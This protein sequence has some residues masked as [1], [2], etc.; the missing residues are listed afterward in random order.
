MNNL[1]QTELAQYILIV[2]GSLLLSAAL[3][4]GISKLSSYGIFN[5]K[6]SGKAVVQRPTV[7][8]QV[9]MLHRPVRISARPISNIVA[10]PVPVSSLQETVRMTFEQTL[11]SSQ[12]LLAA[13]RRGVVPPPSTPESSPG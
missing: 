10:K 11:T 2:L 3:L 6:G 1:T 8:T 7:A 12:K 13:I 4:V 9:A 5:L